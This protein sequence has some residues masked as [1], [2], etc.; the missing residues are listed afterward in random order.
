M[1]LGKDVMW[2]Q[3]GKWEENKDGHREGRWEEGKGYN[4][5][6]KDVL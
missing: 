2:E 6:E 5:R 4:E 3:S 1:T